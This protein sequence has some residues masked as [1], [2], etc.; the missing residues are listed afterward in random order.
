MKVTPSNTQV[1]CFLKES[2]SKGRKDPYLRLQKTKHTNAKNKGG[3]SQ[4]PLNWIKT[5]LDEAEQ[6]MLKF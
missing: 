1:M 5:R 3:Y 4:I 2:R 6:R